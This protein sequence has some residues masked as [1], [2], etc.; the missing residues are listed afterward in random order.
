ML[1]QATLPRRL[2]KGDTM[3]NNNHSVDTVLGEVAKAA[4]PLLVSASTF[5]GFTL[6]EWVYIVTII[7][8]VLQVLRMI[9]F[10]ELWSKYGKRK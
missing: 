8:T 1:T 4:P 3:A 7:Y 2:F 6:Q 9:P 10:K 5:L